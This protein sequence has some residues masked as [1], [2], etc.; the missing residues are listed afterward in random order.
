[1]ADKSLLLTVR[2]GL[3]PGGRRQVEVLLEKYSIWLHMKLFKH[4]NRKNAWVMAKK[5]TFHTFPAEMANTCA[6]RVGFI[7]LSY[8][9]VIFVYIITFFSFLSCPSVRWPDVGKRGERVATIKGF[10]HHSLFLCHISCM[11][12]VECTK[13]ESKDG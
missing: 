9:L 3:Y 4:I 10:L 1:M 8:W 7:M 11:L 5:F 12:I 6:V 2:K 13:N